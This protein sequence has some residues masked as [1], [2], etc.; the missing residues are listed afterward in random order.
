MTLVVASESYK[1]TYTAPLFSGA[2]CFCCLIYAVIII[3]PFLLC[4]MTNNFWILY[5]TN[6]EKIV[7]DFRHE[8]VF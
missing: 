5:T 6:T 7:Y 1:R 3:L 8:Y 4:I 2:S